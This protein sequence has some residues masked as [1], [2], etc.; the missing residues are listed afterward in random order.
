MCCS[1]CAKDPTPEQ[2]EILKEMGAKYS[3]TSQVWQLYPAYT[4]QLTELDSMG[5]K[6]SM[7][8]IPYMYAESKGN[9]NWT[10]D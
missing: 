4:S 2:A 6:Y 10:G 1:I 7:S 8:Y 3:D 9:G 5:L